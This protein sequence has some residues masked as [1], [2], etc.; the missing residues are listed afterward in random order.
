VLTAHIAT[1]VGLLGDS[2]GFLAVSIRA[3]TTNDP[4]VATNSVEVLEMFSLIL[5]RPLSFAALIAR[6]RTRPRY[7]V[8]RVPHL[9][10]QRP[11]RRG[12]GEHL[13][14]PRHDR[15]RP[16]RGLGGLA[17]GLARR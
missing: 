2:A 12:A 5:G 1:S 13:E 8:G 14:L 9:L 6:R 17:G 10:H 3:A 4:D 16:P 11:R 15:P 7:P